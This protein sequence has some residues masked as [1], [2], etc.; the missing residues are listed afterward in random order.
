MWDAII[1][2]TGVL[3]LLGIGLV[4]LLP[5]SGPL[6]GLGI[7]TMWVTGP[8]SPFFPIGLEPI[9]MLF[10]RLYAPLLVAIVSVTFGL[11]IEFLNY[12]VYDALLGLR[13]ARRF[14]ESRAVRFLQRLFGRAPFFTVWLCAWTPLP[15]WGARILATLS[16]YSIARYMTAAALGRLPKFWFFAALGLYWGLTDALLVGI[17]VGTALLATGIWFV[18]R[19]R[20]VS[21]G[22]IAGQPSRPGA[23]EPALR[24][25]RRR[26]AATA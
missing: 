11:Y 15:F 18:G 25:A 8:L 10:G 9:L 7:Y 24:A 2:S 3:G 13:R 5:R 20:N 6:V 26:K 22:R 21:G 1:R 23:R 4:L 17:V 16:N 12:H 14:R 19:R